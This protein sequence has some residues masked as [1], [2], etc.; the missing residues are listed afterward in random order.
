MSGRRAVLR[1]S[2]ESSGGL[3]QLVLQA[4]DVVVILQLLEIAGDVI[5]L[6]THRGTTVRLAS[7]EKQDTVI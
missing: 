4:R 6:H 7:P 2:L 5:T 1:S 3:G